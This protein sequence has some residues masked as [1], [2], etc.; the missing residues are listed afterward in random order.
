[1]CLSNRLAWLPIFNLLRVWQTLPSHYVDRM[2][3]LHQIVGKNRTE[4]Q[5]EAS[6]SHLIV[7]CRKKSRKK[8]SFPNVGVRNRGNLKKIFWKPV[9]VTFSCFLFSCVCQV[10]ACDVVQMFNI[11]SLIG[12]FIFRSFLWNFRGARETCFQMLYFWTILSPTK[13]KFI[14]WIVKSSD[15]Y[16]GAVSGSHPVCPGHISLCATPICRSYFFLLCFVASRGSQLSVD[17]SLRQ[18]QHQQPRQVCGGRGQQVVPSPPVVFHGASRPHLATQTPPA[19]PPAPRSAPATR[20]LQ[21]GLGL[22][23]QGTGGKT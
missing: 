11:L 17:R 10:A 20:R 13:D 5:Q 2:P 14:S 7:N 1:M 23:E 4:S 6:L 3:S 21:A 22:P 19:P 18:Q 9:L 12:Y 15:E 8:S 16:D